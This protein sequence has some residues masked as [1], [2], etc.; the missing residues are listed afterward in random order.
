MP[1]SSSQANVQALQSV[2]HGST[3]MYV[4][5]SQCDVFYRYILCSAVVTDL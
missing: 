2:H 5:I 4:T 1:V 3:Q